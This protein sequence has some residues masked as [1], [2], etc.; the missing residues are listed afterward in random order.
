MRRACE[1]L[2]EK[3]GE[4]IPRRDDKPA[5]SIEN[6]GLRSIASTLRILYLYRKSA[7]YGNGVSREIA[8][9]CVSA[10]RDALRDVEEILYKMQRI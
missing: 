7:D 2:L 6:K 4:K 1:D 5:N 10:A 8:E 9:F 3:Y